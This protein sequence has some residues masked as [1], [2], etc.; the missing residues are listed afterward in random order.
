VLLDDAHIEGAVRKRLA[1]NVDAGADGMAAVIA[2]MRSSLRASMT[3][4]SPKT[5]V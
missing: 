1:E 3:R 4:F 2:T 5:L